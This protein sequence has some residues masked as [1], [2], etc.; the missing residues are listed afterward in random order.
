[1]AKK[2]AVFCDG[3][4]NDLRK[5]IPTNVVRLAKCVAQRSGDGD[6]QIVYYDEGVGVPSRVSWLVDQGTKYIGGALGRGLDQKIEAAYRFLVLNFEPDDEIYIFGF[7]RGAY[8]AR[9]LCG[10]IRKCGILRRA[11][12]TK[13]PEAI[14]R[15]RDEVYPSSPEMVQFRADHAH[16]LASGREDYERFGIEQPPDGELRE[17][18]KRSEVYQY[19]PKQAYQMMFTGIWDTVGALGVPTGLDILRWNRRYKFHDTSASSLLSS[20]RH[21]VAANEKRGLYDVTPFDNFDLLNVEWSRATGWNTVDPL[22]PL[23]VPYAHRP[24][25]QRWFAGDHCSV[26]GGYRETGLSS[27]A[28]LWMADG[29]SWAGLQFIDDPTSELGAAHRHA[30]PFAPLGDNGRVAMPSGKARANGPPNVDE[31]SDPLYLRWGS[32]AEYRP[33]NLHVLRGAP[34]PRPAPPPLP[35]GFPPR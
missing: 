26:G 11:W 13:V 8:T 4:W 28:L 10:L 33:P 30:R 2:L 29:A 3:T 12:F 31:V 19:R 25:Q 16:P 15:Y 18:G 17:R 24:Y 6:P 27:E 22:H 23:F 1:M 21:A 14:K 34:T 32:A 5:D 9:S 35:P 7:S 20:I